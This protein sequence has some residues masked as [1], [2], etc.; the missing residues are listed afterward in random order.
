ML[1]D[2]GFEVYDQPLTYVRLVYLPNNKPPFDDIRVRKAF[3]HAVD[4]VAL[5]AIATEGA[6]QPLYGMMSPAIAGYDPEVE[7]HGY[8][9]NLPRAK[10]LM[11]EAG[12]TYGDDGMLLTP[13]GEPFKLEL[14][15]PSEPPN[16]KIAEVLQAQWKALG[17]DITIYVEE[18]GSVQGSRLNAGD[19]DLSNW[20]RGGRD[21]DIMYHLFRSGAVSAGRFAVN[22]PKLDAMMDANRT[23]TDPRELQKSISEAQI[24]IA[25]NVFGI[26]LMGPMNRQAH[27]P[28]V[29]GVVWNNGANVI[30]IFANTYLSED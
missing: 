23:L 6:E 15:S 17:V 7:K 3:S 10:E 22:D 11:Q 12:Y 20:L 25:E 14:L 8:P 27:S 30:P 29:K 16:H 4:R 18:S 13:D 9:Y 5:S 21:W 2:R 19:F 1:K 24:Y 28:R 26:F